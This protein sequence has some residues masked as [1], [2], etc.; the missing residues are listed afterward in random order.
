MQHIPS[1]KV[2][3]KESD[4]SQNKAKTDIVKKF[5][6]SFTNESQPSYH[7]RNNWILVIKGASGVGKKT[8]AK[9]LAKQVGLDVW[10]E[11]EMEVE[12]IG[13]FYADSVNPGTQPYVSSLKIFRETVLRSIKE[14]NYINRKLF[15][16]DDLPLLETELE[17]E[18]LFKF[19]QRNSKFVERALNLGE[20]L[21]PIVFLLNTSLYNY[22]TIS[23]MM[24]KGEFDDF[25]SEVK[26]LDVSKTKLK[27]IGFN[28][29][30]AHERVHKYKYFMRVWNLNENEIIERAQGDISALKN[31]MIEYKL[32][33]RAR[34]TKSI[35]EIASQLSQPIKQNQKI[36]KVR[37]DRDVDLFHFL[38]KILYNKRLKPGA[39]LTDLKK[40]T[41][42]AETEQEYNLMK[43]NF[44]FDLRR[45]IESRTTAGRFSDQFKHVIFR[46][47]L[48]FVGFWEYAGEISRNWARL[49]ARDR[50]MRENRIL[51]QNS[52]ENNYLFALAY[53]IGNKV[54][55]KPNRLYLFDFPPKLHETKAKKLLAKSRVKYMRY[56]SPALED[57][58]K[59]KKLGSKVWQ[60][61]KKEIKFIEDDIEE[62]DD[63]ILNPK[64]DESSPVN[65]SSGTKKIKKNFEVDILKSYIK[66]N[67][68][69]EGKSQ[70]EILEE[71]IAKSLPDDF[72]KSI[73]E[74]KTK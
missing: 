68:N 1:T 41:K 55:I 53:M 40:C 2:I 66:K 50:I 13:Q 36:E 52:T 31:L 70:N 8:I 34:R 10:T 64:W 29:A 16:I 51:R 26:F 61:E 23:Y 38:G 6:Y 21:L 57:F 62:V 63:D 5:L 27:K 65:R 15:L 69:L 54:P 30:Q 18:S 48:S 12:I 20:K 59:V 73:N 74:D 58:S 47:Y 42:S 28:I 56:M 71:M 45:L 44:Y 14:R 43:Q 9:Y 4:L 67:K 22:K 3:N 49:L 72:L 35:A 32:K 46:H 33:F 37:L 24:N 11:R 17:R 7:D 60:S 25:I 19:W 39:K